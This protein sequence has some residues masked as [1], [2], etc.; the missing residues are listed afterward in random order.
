[1][2]SLKI[3]IELKN[4]F[5][6]FQQVFL[7]YFKQVI[8][9]LKDVL[10][11]ALCEV[12]ATWRLPSNCQLLRP[13]AEIPFAIS[14]QR[15]NLYA[16]AE[17]PPRAQS[18]FGE[19]RKSSS[20]KE[21]WF[22]E[23]LDSCQL[24]DNMFCDNEEFPEYWGTDTDISTSDC[25]QQ[26][27]EVGNDR[28]F[29][30]GINRSNIVHGL[31]A[32]SKD[33]DNE[34]TALEEPG[35]QFETAEKIEPDQSHVEDISVENWRKI[36][37]IRLYSS[38]TSTETED[39]CQADCE[40]RYDFPKHLNI[41]NISYMNTPEKESSQRNSDFNHNHYVIDS[42]TKYSGL[43]AS[44]DVICN[45]VTHNDVIYNDVR[46]DEVIP[47]DLKSVHKSKE[48][49]IDCDSYEMDDDIEETTEIT[50]DK[51]DS[52]WGSVLITGYIGPDIHRERI[53]LCLNGN[54]S[55]SISL[56]QMA[57]KKF[58]N[59]ME[60]T[61]DNTADSSRIEKDIAALSKESRVHSYMTSITIVDDM[62]NTV[63]V[64]QTSWASR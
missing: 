62:E 55:H 6:I 28:E 19:K 39:E 59:G 45:D 50:S 30:V 64:S 61:L 36:R 48:N 57:A 52:D 44:H 38:D 34:E 14:G 17:L 32:S 63:C 37:N 20:V 31:A 58:I 8:Q 3:F 4:L 40:N 21:F 9:C 42:V 7:N 27:D 24:G 43:E 29:D 26:Y 46:N 16:L 25:E 60:A 10:K 11:P 23:E 18:G 49:V 15:I 2:C 53:P 35:D 13:S 33:C 1:L 22:D 41:E 47:N 5:K 12:T 51:T 54:S 56:H